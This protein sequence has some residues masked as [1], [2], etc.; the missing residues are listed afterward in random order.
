MT[1]W[2]KYLMCFNVAGL[3]GREHV[4]GLC[5]AT[6][7]KIVGEGR[8]SWMAQIQS[9]DYEYDLLCEVEMISSAI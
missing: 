8:T 6:W 3:G 4:G 9:S 7:L 2:V 5:C 1:V